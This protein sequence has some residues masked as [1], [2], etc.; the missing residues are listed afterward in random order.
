MA[1]S[2]PWQAD[3]H[4]SAVSIIK[5]LLVRYGAPKAL[6]MLHF[7][8]LRLWIGVCM[9]LTCIGSPLEGTA[10]LPPSQCTQMHGATQCIM[11]FELCPDLIVSRPLKE[12]IS[13]MLTSLVIGDVNQCA[14]AG[15]R[16][17]SIQ[18]S[19]LFCWSVSV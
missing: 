2:S 14:F 13:G 11:S 1:M 16:M 10:Y 12:H 8:K 9:D 5:M 15:H 3:L 6:T 17:L 4:L 7:A 18:I 19:A